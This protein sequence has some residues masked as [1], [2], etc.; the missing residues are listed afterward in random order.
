MVSP[1][2]FCIFSL[3]CVENL[4]LSKPDLRRCG[5]R[6]IGHFR[7]RLLV[8]GLF[9]SRSRDERIYIARGEIARNK[10]RAK[11]GLDGRDLGRDEKGQATDSF[12]NFEDIFS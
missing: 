5:L 11:G 12:G 2:Y 1:S 3:F 9:L 10:A 7:L 6:G 8:V 4:S